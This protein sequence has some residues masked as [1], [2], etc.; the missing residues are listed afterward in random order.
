MGACCEE[1]RE[2]NCAKIRN[3]KF[4]G[5][6]IDNRSIFNIVIQS[7][8]LF[9]KSFVLLQ[10]GE[11]DEILDFDALLDMNPKMLS[12]PTAESDHG[13]DEDDDNYE[14]DGGDF[15]DVDVV[16]EYVGG[17]NHDEEQSEVAVASA[18]EVDEHDAHDM[19]ED[20]EVSGSVGV[21][22]RGDAKEPVSAASLHVAAAMKT[23]S[24]SRQIQD[25]DSDS[26]EAVS[27]KQKKTVKFHSDAIEAD[28]SPEEPIV[29]STFNVDSVKVGDGLDG[30]DQ[31][32]DGGDG[33]GADGGAENSDADDAKS[34]RR[35]Q[36][37]RKKDKNLMYRMM[38]LE[39]A[40]KHRKEKR[41]VEDDG[42]S[43]T[44]LC[45]RLRLYFFF[46]CAVTRWFFLGAGSGGGGGRGIAGGLGR[47][48]FRRGE[49]T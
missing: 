48:W 27:G 43:V 45:N 8:L 5:G 3:E 38:L 35:K 11:D 7:L 4:D 39:E 34:D 21:E 30:T 13:S 47:L 37:G 2:T 1:N 46:T 17:D 6:S 14:D 36:D 31:G 20:K 25:S 40:K 28:G 32:E 29:A 41:K 12:A 9:I 10:S 26:D 42:C 49:G 24:R 22:V 16:D 23:Y 33:Q 18:A 19:D 15:G 44:E